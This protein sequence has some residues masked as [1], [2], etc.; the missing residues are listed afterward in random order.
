MIVVP[1]LL[2]ISFLMIP[3]AEF[4]QKNYK[5]E[6]IELDDADRV[7]NKPLLEKF[8]VILSLLKYMVPLFLVNL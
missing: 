2:A 4:V 5:I 3:T 7:E 6:S 1:V 8:N